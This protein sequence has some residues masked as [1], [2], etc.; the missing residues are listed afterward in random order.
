MYEPCVACT[1]KSPSFTAPCGH[2][3]L[4]SDCL[5]EMIK[6]TDQKNLNCPICRESFTVS[7]DRMLAH[8]SITKRQMK[9]IDDAVEKGDSQINFSSYDKL[10]KEVYNRLKE[11]GYVNQYCNEFVYRETSNHSQPKDPGMCCGMLVGC[12][13][14][15]GFEFIV[16]VLPAMEKMK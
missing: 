4:C 13:M 12:L 7:R 14:T 15:L 16:I 11:L 6:R 2:K 1:E 9:V 10:T 3:V 8:N 5:D